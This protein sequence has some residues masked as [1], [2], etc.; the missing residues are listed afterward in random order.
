MVR[1]FISEYLFNGEWH[2]EPLEILMIAKLR[3]DDSQNQF[4][5]PIRKGARRLEDYPNI[6]IYYKSP[7]YSSLEH[8]SGKYGWFPASYVK[9]V[10]QTNQSAKTLLE[11][12]Y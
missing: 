11:S 1:K 3:P 2:K 7:N 8:L 10:R 4:L 6:Q 9:V 5:L 12:H